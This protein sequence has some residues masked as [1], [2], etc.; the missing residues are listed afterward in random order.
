MLQKKVMGFVLCAG[1]LGTLWARD[2]DRAK[3]D[4]YFDALEASGR[5]MG[6][7]AISSKGELLYARALG[8]ADV[9]QG[10]RARTDSR[11]RIGSI[12]KTFTAT[13][14]MLAVEE[15]KL[16]LE[17][18]LEGFFPSLPQAER[19]TVAQLLGHRSGIRSFTDDPAYLTWNT[20]TRTQAQMVALI[21]K[22]GRV[23]AP[24]TRAEYSN[25]NYVLLTFILEKVQGKP[26]GDLLA[27]HITGPLGL[28]DTCLGG[29]IDPQQNDCRSYTYRGAW[30]LAPETDPSIPLGAGGVVSTASDLVRF[31]DALLGG[32]ILR[33][34]SLERMKTLEDGYG[35]GLFSFPFQERRAYGH[36]GG[37]DGFSSVFS[38]FGQEGVSCAL[39]SNGTRYD[40]NAISVTL[41]SAIFGQPFEIPVFKTHEVTPEALEAYLGVYA[42]TQM[43][44]KITVTREGHT[45]MAQ[46]TG[47]GAIPLDPTGE[48]VFSFD[49]AGIEMIFD[50]SR[51]TFILKQGGGT[52]MFTRE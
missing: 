49:P 48:H 23:F 5:F 10:I 39:V 12:S 47:Q 14:A 16:R 3:L 1:F 19:I 35:L 7:V 38:H 8:M 6:N 41:L 45:L 22:G 13:L 44:L 37:I 40:N 31:A 17:Q 36:T 4:R 20:Q 11:Y 26:Y 27:E 28:K 21:A 15:G 46:A 52:F 29:R 50:P 25:S 18:T 43:P 32:K 9:E 33:P 42:S 24:G 2:F 30:R 34:E 51:G